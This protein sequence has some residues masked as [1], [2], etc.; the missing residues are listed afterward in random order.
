MFDLE[1]LD[2]SGW[3]DGKGMASRVD[4]RDSGVALGTADNPSPLEI[5][6]GDGA[7]TNLSISS[8]SGS[9]VL[10]RSLSQMSQSSDG[11]NELNSL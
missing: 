1:L 8:S 10:L 9:L 7:V 3:G 6:A 11:S 4:P 5:G 2:G